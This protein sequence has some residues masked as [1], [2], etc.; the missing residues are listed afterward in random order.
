[1]TGD[2]AMKVSAMGGALPGQVAPSPAAAMDAAAFDAA[3]QAVSLE[4]AAWGHNSGPS[5]LAN[6]AN[7]LQNQYSHAFDMTG[8]QIEGKSSIEATLDVARKQV[9]ID[10][11]QTALN[12]AW[13]G[14]KEV[15]KGIETV[16]NSK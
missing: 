16:M 6:M 9:H 8:M 2:L 5:A 13:A 4:P 7:Q 10:Q 3:W 15:R 14:V 11:A 1:M 12:L